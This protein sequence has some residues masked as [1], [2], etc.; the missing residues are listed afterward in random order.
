MTVFAAVETLEF[1][2]VE[3]DA[4][5]SAANFAVS[6]LEHAA[7]IF[8]SLFSSEIVNTECELLDDVSTGSEGLFASLT[9]TKDEVDPVI[10]TFQ[11]MFLKD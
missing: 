2:V 5:G 9:S 1:F 7:S 10:F 6:I 3:S 4:R 8:A 11:T